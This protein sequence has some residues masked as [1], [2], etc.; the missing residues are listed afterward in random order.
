MRSSGDNLATTGDG[1]GRART[2]R[3]LITAND[4]SLSMEAHDALSAAVAARSGFAGLWASGLSNASSPGY[5]NANEAA[6]TQFVDVVERMSDATDCP[7]LV[8][9]DSD[10]GNF[11]NAQLAALRLW[12]RGAVAPPRGARCRV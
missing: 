10:F 5:R 3:Q 1:T 6:W 4:L 12:Q 9:G 2:L 11:N 8:D 7:V